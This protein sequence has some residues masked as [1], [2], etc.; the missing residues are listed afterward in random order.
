M[1]AHGLARLGRDAEVRRTPSGEAVCNLSLAFNVRN[2]GEQETTWVEA[3]LWGKR[4]ESLAPYLLK[5]SMHAF[6]LSDVRIE[7]YEGR[8]GSGTKLVA[9]VVD[10]TLGPKATG[11]GPAKAPGRPQERSQQGDPIKTPPPRAASGSGFDDMEDD[12]PF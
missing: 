7:A 10:V 8:N 6:D 9:N 4:A 1:K 11:E 3:A 12:I 5:G 2:K